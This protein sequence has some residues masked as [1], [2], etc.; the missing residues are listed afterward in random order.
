MSYRPF[1]HRSETY[2]AGKRGEGEGGTEEDHRGHEQEGEELG[3]GEE[4]ERHFIAEIEVL[5]DV[6][7]LGEFDS[8]TKAAEAHDRALM[9][10]VGPGACSYLSSSSS[11]STSSV[12]QVSLSMS[13]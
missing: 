13:L 3:G 2:K 9:R 4:G 11:T 8:P 7:S 5:G 12:L 1:V 6:V 10:A